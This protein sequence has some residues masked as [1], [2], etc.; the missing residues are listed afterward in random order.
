MCFLFENKNEETPAIFATKKSYDSD[1]FFVGFFSYQREF[2]SVN[3][4][5]K[6]EIRM[7]YNPR[8][9]YGFSIPKRTLCA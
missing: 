5:R 7:H 6:L 9:V 1:R 4:L 3:T 8:F 2:C